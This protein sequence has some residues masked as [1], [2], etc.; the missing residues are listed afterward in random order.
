MAVVFQY[1]SNMSVGR[2]N[3]ADRLAGD[4]KLIGVAGTVE[5]HELAFTVRSRT[6]NCAAADIIPS[7]AGRGICGVL[8][9]IPD[10]LL[11][12]GTAKARR[13]LDAIEGEDT[14]YDRKYVEVVTPDGQKL[15][16][17]TY[18]VRNRKANLKTSLAYVRHILCGLREHGLPEDYF[19]YVLSRVIENN[20]ELRPSLP[21]WDQLSGWCSE[22]S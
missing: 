6:N 15:M 8:Y 7:D 10:F 16:A 3:S 14:N 13:S 20:S 11:S 9:D 4:A 2:L 17:L 22:A 19:Q 1:G 18:V 21:Q 5:P 12:R